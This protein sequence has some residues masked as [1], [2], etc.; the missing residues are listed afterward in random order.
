MSPTEEKKAHSHQ[1][2]TPRHTW[3]PGL[4]TRPASSSVWLSC[5]RQTRTVCW[6]RNQGRFLKG[7]DPQTRL[8]KGGARL[9]A[10]CL[11]PFCPAHCV[12]ITDAYLK[13]GKHKN[14]RLDGGRL[15]P[16]SESAKPLH[17]QRHVLGK[18][19]TLDIIVYIQEGTKLRL[20]LPQTHWDL[21]LLFT[22]TGS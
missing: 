11:N 9:F 1:T 2:F 12:F 5:P 17:S 14:R 4:N 20:L 8:L 13:H 16:R 3:S 15:P 7:G 6:R 21:P 19:S 22:Q 18:L 10:S